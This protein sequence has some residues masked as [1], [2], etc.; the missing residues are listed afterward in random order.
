MPN[1]I[2]TL[3][4]DWLAMS[5]DPGTG[6]VRYPMTIYFPSYTRWSPEHKPGAIPGLQPCGREEG[7][8]EEGGAGGGGARPHGTPLQGS[9]A[10]Q[11]M[12]FVSCSAGIDPSVRPAVFSSLCC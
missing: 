5:H 1:A 11:I 10:N 6:D 2:I 9:V 12:G 7:V 4:S 8:C 3:T